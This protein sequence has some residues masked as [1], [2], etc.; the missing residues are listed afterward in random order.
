MPKQTTSKTR[1]TPGGVPGA[2]YDEGSGASTATV[3]SRRASYA[4]RK[5]A[6]KRI[7]VRVGPRGMPVSLRYV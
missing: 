3:S 5:E 7:E 1:L 6:A 2:S 4:F